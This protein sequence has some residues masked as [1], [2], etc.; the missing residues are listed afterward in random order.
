MDVFG[1]GFAATGGPRP[2]DV[3]GLTGRNVELY[4]PLSQAIT[5]T[6]GRDPAEILDV[7]RTSARHWPYER[8]DGKWNL[9][10]RNVHTDEPGGIE[11]ELGDYGLVTLADAKRLAQGL[12]DQRG[13]T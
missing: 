1:Q 4:Q 13:R 9:A 10:V 6:I 7:P 8:S 2:V 12:A 5:R 3:D 11:E